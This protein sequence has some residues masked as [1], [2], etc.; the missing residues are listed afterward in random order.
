[1]R[2]SM[3]KE[4]ARL[5]A[6][7]VWAD[8]R[9]Q[10]DHVPQALAVALA[11]IVAVL[12]LVTAARLWTCWHTDALMDHVSGIW[13][14]AADD[15][16][17]GTLYRLPQSALGYGGTRY[18]PLFTLLL[19]GAWRL[20]VNWR[21]AAYGLSLASVVLLL[22]GVY[23][24][25][26]RCG[27]TS[28]IS[29]CGAAAV[30]AGISTQEQLLSLRPD[31]VAAALNL[32]GVALCLANVEPQRTQRNAKD[33]GIPLRPFASFAVSSRFFPIGAA[34]L[35]ALAAAVKMTTVFG[36]A[37]VV[38]ALALSGQR[39]QAVRL[40]LATAIAYAAVIALTVHFG[41]P[42]FLENMRLAASAGA[43][44]QSFLRAPLRLFDIIR[45]CT[46]EALFLVAAAACL[47][48]SCCENREGTGRNQRGPVAFLPSM[49]FLVSLLGTLGIYG[50]PGTN[51][52]HLVDLY[53]AS[54]IT[55]LAYL[56]ANPR[57]TAAGMT[58]FAM[59]LGAATSAA[60]VSHRYLD[61]TD[62]RALRAEAMASIAP[63]AGPV[64]SENP[65]FPLMAGQRPYVL[66]PFMLRVI[67][68]RH[69][70]FADELRRQLAERKFAAVVLE[71]DPRS[72]P[73]RWFER[74]HF[75]P[76]F[77]PL[78]EANYEP[79]APPGYI[80]VYKPK[81]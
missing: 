81:Q 43:T 4:D 65:L 37:A 2:F 12:L 21:L 56:L 29:W 48:A 39:W 15:F 69:P 66:D 42:A 41:G 13:L 73:Q 20:A 31:A 51:R 68:A 76:W 78:L 27:A 47:I 23:A 67:A 19:A 77:V 33:N 25:L 75:G 40:A 1:M 52:N 79:V 74:T 64:L 55:A 26:R 9:A 54:V 50:S 6:R 14:A 34:V 11:A 49:L 57:R 61:G 80:V 3:V 45:Q 30:L 10:A 5:L 58:V 62:N 36:A 18:F 59:A 71:H 44:R 22:G 32:W 72:D 7:M 60:Y 46:G 35:F 38:L 24:V 16:H 17:H 70:H 28:F 8:A 63:V 53:A